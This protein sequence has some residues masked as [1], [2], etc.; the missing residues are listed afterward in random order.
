MQI[1]DRETAENILEEAAKLNPTPW[2]KHSQNAGRAAE[3]I[4]GKHPDLDPDTAYVLGLLH[5]I[6]RR[7]GVT[8]M[9]HTLDGYQYLMSLGYPGAARISMTHSFPL[10][11][12]NSSEKPKQPGFVND[13]LPAAGKWD[14]SDEELEVVKAFLSN[15]TYT[16]YDKLIQLCDA[17]SLPSGYCLIDK[18]MVDVTLRHG[19]TEYTVPRWKAFFAI[20][21]EFEEAMGCSIYS[22]LPGVVENTF[23]TGDVT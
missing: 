14:C 10:R 2:V 22:L 12:N 4:A 5:D 11:A 16:P 19:V 7:V 20:Q 1:P 17:L 21:K 15:T 23:G 8:D 3:L 9:R 13:C 6:G 18:R